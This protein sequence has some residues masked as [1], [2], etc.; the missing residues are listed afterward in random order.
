MTEWKMKRFWRETAVIE[1]AGLFAIALDGE[2]VRTPGKAPLRLPSRA[3]A[4]AARDE[5]EAQQDVI[6]PHAMPVTR[7]ANTAIDKVALEAE[8]VA[9]H[10]TEYGGTD[11]LCYRAEAPEPLVRRQAE[12]WDPLLDWAAE[13]LGARLAVGT[14]VMHVAQDPVALGRLGAQ[15][16]ALDPFRLTA[17]SDL[18]TLSGSLVIGFAVTEGARSPEAAWALSRIDEDWQT[19]QWGEDEEAGR[20]AGLKRA[21]FLEAA[22]IFRLVSG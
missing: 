7:V 16:R 6:N 22:R 15:V 20:Q 9:A 21:A 4:E 10:L 17:F 19:E 5:W 18:V 11:L 14:G 13:A 1:E 2:R 3:M 12:G 8:A